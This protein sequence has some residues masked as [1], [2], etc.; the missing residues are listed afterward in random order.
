MI[1]LF[2]ADDQKMFI[3]G[4][5]SILSEEE[6]IKIEGVAQNGV[7]LMNLLEKQEPDVVLLD[8]NMPEMD[9]IE[10]CK[11]LKKK[12]QNIKILILST[13]SN[14]SFVSNMV[15]L[16]ADGYLLKNTGKEELILAIESVYG[17][18]PYYSKEIK[19]LL[20]VNSKFSE[21]EISFLS[22]REIEVLTLIGSGNTNAEIAELLFL[23]PYTVETHRKNMMHKLQLKNTA[24]LVK[25]AVDRGLV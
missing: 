2:L 15:S 23:S 11:A 25:Y 14:K 17:G 16:G 6:N 20:D 12:Y 19:E 7:E 24:E 22:K 10:T 4:L 5:Q 21:N 18:E 8:I 1:T 9:G 13:Y 3:N